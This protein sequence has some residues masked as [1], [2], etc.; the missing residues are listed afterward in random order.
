MGKKALSGRN[1]WQGQGGA[2]ALEAETNLYEVFDEYFK[3]SEYVLHK[4]PMHLKNLYANISLPEEVLRQ[5]YNPQI[6]LK[7][8]K[9]GV[10]PDFAIEN[11]YTHKI[12]FGEIKRQDGWVEGKNPSAGRGNAH[13]RLCKLFTP[14]LLKAYREIGHIKNPEILPFWVVFEG[15]ITRDPKRNR[16]IAF[17]FDQYNK[18][19]F[20]WRPN[21]TGQDLIDHFDKYL[22]P[23]LE[24]NDS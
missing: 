22:K 18:N 23:Y 4:K 9:W 1:N 11:T 19:Y 2:K 15:D 7:N 10:S 16:E 21:M 13:E 12:L 14:G 6:S 17:W 24:E 5:M 20:M 8:T 3:N